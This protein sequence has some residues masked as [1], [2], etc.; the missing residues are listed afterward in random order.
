MRV[1]AVHARVAGQR[2][3]VGLAVV[4]TATSTCVGHSTWVAPAS[5]NTAG[6]L[7]EL[8]VR[9]RELLERNDAEVLV[10]WTTEPA[11]GG[12]GRRAQL[13]DA[14]RAE[15][16]VMAA[17]GAVATVK[18][19]VKT[20]NAAVRAVAGNGGGTKESVDAVAASISGLPK[21]EAVRRAAAAALAWRRRA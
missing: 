10:T 6:Q 19:V 7:Q 8:Y 12:A 4:D 5:E 11:P 18:Q 3:T 16:T 1:G 15:G 9:A 14:S 2:H 21:D 20:G 17:A 13:I